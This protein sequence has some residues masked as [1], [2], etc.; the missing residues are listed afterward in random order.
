MKRLIFTA[1]LL[2]T[3][4]TAFAQIT[5]QQCLMTAGGI[6]EVG[7]QRDRGVSLWTAF[8]TLR[9]GGVPEEVAFLILEVVFI[10][11]Q[12]NPPEEIANFF[13]NYCIS[14]GL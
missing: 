7:A 5:D 4:A 14:E 8:N 1:A 9:M 2:M 12:G 10:D 3:P 6:L 11:Q 13:Y